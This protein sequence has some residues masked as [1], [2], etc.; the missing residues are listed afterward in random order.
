MP[1]GFEG[2]LW[3]RDRQ[4]LGT[5]WVRVQTPQESESSSFGW[6]G[7]GLQFAKGTMPVK[8]RDV[9]KDTAGLP[10]LRVPVGPAPAM[11]TQGHAA[12]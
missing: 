7:S 8:H 2:G 3:E 1:F 4:S 11:A 10:T 9:R 12:D 6:W 5:R